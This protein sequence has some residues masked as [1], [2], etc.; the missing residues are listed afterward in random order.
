MQVLHKMTQRH[1]KLM[2]F[3]S[4]MI[5]LLMAVSFQSVA[6][7]S[8]VHQS[9]QSGAEHLEFEHEHEG[10]ANLKPM[11]ESS[12]FDCHHCCHCHGDHVSSMLPP[13][14]SLA[15]LELNQAIHISEHSFTSN[16]ASRLLRP[17]K[18]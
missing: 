16:L 14:F 10:D 12:S 3:K 8:D 5:L 4:L 17:P 1:F 6:S 15:Y 13:S 11:D 18:A 7:V 9:H 2:R